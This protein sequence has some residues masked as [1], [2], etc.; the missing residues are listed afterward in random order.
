MLR[1][2]L[3]TLLAEVGNR[4]EIADAERALLR[5]SVQDLRDDVAQL[6]RQIGI[7]AERPPARL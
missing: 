4:L 6:R 2:E 3:K 1:D 5:K 7:G